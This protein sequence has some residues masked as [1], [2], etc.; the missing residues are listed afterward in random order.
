MRHC[1]S[2]RQHRDL[3]WRRPEDFAERGKEPTDEIQIHTW[4]D[5]TLREL[6][7]LIKEVRPVARRRTAR[8][9]F[10]FAFPDQRSGQ[11]LVKELSVVHN[12][13]TTPTDTRTLRSYRFQPGDYLDV[14]VYV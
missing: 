1:A 4:P 7:D 8:L 2:P 3:L 11:F 6:A 13:R 9:S 14:A 5:A 10:A 12:S